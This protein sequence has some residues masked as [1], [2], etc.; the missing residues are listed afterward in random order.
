M[1]SRLFKNSIRMIAITAILSSCTLDNYDGPDASISGG[2]YDVETKE[3]LP[4]DI[5]QGSVIEYTEHGYENP[6]LQTMVFK[7]DGTYTN[8]LMFSGTYTIAPVR[9]N[10]VTAEAEEIEVSGKTKKDFFVQPYIRIKNC[11]IQKEGDKI[12]ATFNLEQTTNDPIK[13]IGL[14]AHEGEQVGEYLRQAFVEQNINALADPSIQYKLE[15]N[16][17]STPALKA[18]KQYYFRVGALT[19]VAERKSNYVTAVRIG[20]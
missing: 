16:L 6:Q 7:V 5:V 12:V 14:Y 18:G 17:A 9:G 19:N 15:I 2:I 10:F 1:K 4:Q 20:L 13:K 3:L 11:N 8:N